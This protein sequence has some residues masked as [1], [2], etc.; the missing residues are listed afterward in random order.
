MFDKEMSLVSHLTELRKR[1]IFCIVPFLLAVFCAFPFS[2]G[3][4]N[5]L[6]LPAK[7]IIVGLAFFSPQEVAVVYI[8]TA[9]FGG[10]ILSLPVILFQLWK[11]ISPAVSENVRKYVLLF[12]LIAFISF[13]SGCGFA[14]YFLLPTSLKFLIGLAG[15]DFVQVISISKYISFA[16]V[17]ILGC[18]AAFEL[19][20]IIW[21]LAK[22]GIVKEKFLREKRK[23]AV[24]VIFVLAAI[25]TP[26][27][28]PVNMCLL[29]LPMLALYEIG[30]WAIHFSIKEKV[31]R[32]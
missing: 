18:G 19:P 24:A 6:R 30:I 2:R 8:K 20:I 17:L 26:T 32:D 11:F 22:I 12:V 3:I 4:L 29:A 9:I 14:Y 15:N 5:F 27:T 28:D 13:L 7:G 10:F 25:I 16:L 23:Y 31:T 1:L 21:I